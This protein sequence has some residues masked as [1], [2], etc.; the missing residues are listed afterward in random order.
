VDT[1]YLVSMHRAAPLLLA[2]LA[3]FTSA[4]GAGTPLTTERVASG[5]ERPL[6]VTHAPGDAIRVFVVEQP[7]RVRILDLTQQPP[8]L[9]PQPFLDITA[10]VRSAGN[11]QGLLGLAFHA[12]FAANHLFYVNYTDL[13]GDTVVSRFEVPAGTPDQADPG[14]ELVLLGIDQPQGNHNGGWLAFGPRDGLL[15]IGSGD[16]G[17]AGDD[18]AGHTPG[19]GNA[20][21]T[22][23]NLLGKILRIDVDGTDGP[24]GN[25]GIPL[26]NPFVGKPGD[27]E[28][29]AYG[30]R[31]PWR[32]AF[33]AQTGDL[34]I[35]D[36]GQS[37]WE[38]VNFQPAASAGGENWGWRCREGAHD[39]NTANCG[40]LTPLDPI[41]EYAHGG[42]PFRCSLTGGE[43]YRGCAVPDLA[44][45][46]FFADFC[47]AQIWSFR[48]DAGAV[49]NFLERT[50]EL[51]VGG[52]SIDDVTSFGRDARGELY[53]VDRGGEIF[54]II[55]DGAP[56]ACESP[57][58]PMPSG[59]AGLL[60]LCLVLASAA[61]L[62]APTPPRERARA[63]SADCAVPRTGRAHRFCLGS[64]RSQ[65]KGR[66]R[67]HSESPHLTRLSR[68]DRASREM[69][70]CPRRRRR[71]PCSAPSPDRRRRRRSRCPARAGGRRPAC[72]WRGC[73]ATWRRSR[74]PARPRPRRAPR[75]RPPG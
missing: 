6:F 34:Y 65:M 46:Y 37:L 27:D 38:E 62:R 58:V 44:G 26:G 72:R 7:G 28:I 13:A 48:V 67:T 39:F 36:V 42:S 1:D 5:L 20:Q 11:E 64:A 45:T 71:R 50:G 29:W 61:A 69:R 17:G 9:L 75:P 2:G 57:P 60:G 19:T 68:R 24:T 25:Y 41:H 55:P 23:D 32:N 10:R 21:D 59:A 35:A 8:A 16:G 70:R 53:I 51:A 40:G 66:G 12:D 63:G 18:D 3:P 31:N 56:S 43:V 74:A 22:S 30:L 54:R 15:Y 52:F 73:A 14:S 49:A 47:S 4:A 33:D